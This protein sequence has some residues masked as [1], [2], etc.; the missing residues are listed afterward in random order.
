MEST[1]DLSERGHTIGTTAEDQNPP[2]NNLF[3]SS[4]DNIKEKVKGG[5]GDEL[6]VGIILIAKNEREFKFNFQ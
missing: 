5:N 6:L 2:M 1:I 3:S 4:S